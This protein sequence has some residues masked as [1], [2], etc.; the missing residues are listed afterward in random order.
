MQEFIQNYFIAPIMQN[1]WY[2]P[3]N[4]IVYS[5]LLIIGVYLVYMMLKKLDV[6]IDRNFFIAILPFIVWGSSTRVLH[7]AAYAGVLS[8]GLNT[9]Y[10]SPIFPTPGSYIITFVLALAV[11]L[12]SLLIQRFGRFPYWKA[13]LGIGIVL[14]IINFIM[15]PMVNPFPM[16]LILGVTLAWAVAFFGSGYIFTKKPLSKAIP[17]FKDLFS[18]SNSGILA[19][20]FLD[21][22]ATVT[23]LSLFGYLEQHV[24]PRMFFPFMGP[25][26]MFFLKIAVVLP[27]LWIVDRYADDGDF[28][29][30]LKIVILILGL[31]PGM[32][33]MIRLGAMV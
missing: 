21:A 25:A 1:G 23:A 6:H 28:K 24:V 13:M 8:P 16:I 26:A 15:I 22:T 12:I 14:C 18:V 10:N 32:R 29:N 19:A 30:F 2:N 17:H 31:A 3:I 7:D 20:H 9:F 27:V 11:L 5:I 33:D 4:T